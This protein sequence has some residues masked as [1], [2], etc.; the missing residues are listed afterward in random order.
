MTVEDNILTDKDRKSLKS[1]SNYWRE[2]AK[3]EDP[4][5]LDQEL[6]TVIRTLGTNILFII[7]RY[8]ELT[9]EDK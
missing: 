9:E 6:Y 1:M 5:P 4:S 7:A 8:I 2:V 3:R